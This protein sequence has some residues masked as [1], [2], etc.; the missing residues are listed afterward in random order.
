MG[1]KKITDKQIEAMKTIKELWLEYRRPPEHREICER[2]GMTNIAS[3]SKI[4]KASGYLF[5]VASIVLSDIEVSF[6]GN[7]DLHDR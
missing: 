4:L 2:L 1:K 6:N 3:M 5:D 7:Y